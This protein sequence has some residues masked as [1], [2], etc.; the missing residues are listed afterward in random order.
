MTTHNPYGILKTLAW[1]FNPKGGVDEGMEQNIVTYMQNHNIMYKYVIEHASQRHMHC[2]VIVASKNA[3]QLIR[4]YLSR[5]YPDTFPW[6][7]R[8]IWLKSKTWYKPVEGMQSWDDYLA[9]DG[10]EIHEH[11]MPGDYMEILADNLSPEERQKRDPWPEMTMYE[12]K[13]EE[14]DLPYTTFE[15]VDKGIAMLAFVHRVV[16]PPD[17]SKLKGFT[18]YLWKFLNKDGSGTLA[19]VE[20]RIEE[21]TTARKRRRLDADDQLRLQFIRELD[22]DIPWTG[23]EPGSGVPKIT[24]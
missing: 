20:N 19:S 22:E 4:K 9:K 6:D 5:H 12:Q 24:N 7:Q 15:D 2:G 21:E 23:A 14:F 10:G 13:F 3:A 16:K 8:Q 1:T 18:M 17:G 11:D